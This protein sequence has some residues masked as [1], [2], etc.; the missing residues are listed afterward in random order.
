MARSS[1]CAV[2]SVIGSVMGPPA[3]SIALA[4]H[5]LLCYQASMT[6]SN[7]DD[8]RG[9]PPPG[10]SDRGRTGGDRPFHG[11][12][13]APRKPREGDERRPPRGGSDK[14]FRK[15]RESGDRPFR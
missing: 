3:L 2:G 12:D 1:A 10:G 7:D 5:L 4:S 11:R 6:D 8:R 14:P 15:P 9:R 13:S